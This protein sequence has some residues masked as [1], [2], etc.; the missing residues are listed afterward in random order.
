[1][2]GPCYVVQNFVSFLVAGEERVD[3]LTFIVF[4]EL[5]VAVIILSL[6]RGA[7]F[8]VCIV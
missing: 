5:Y 3:C 1:M 8:L 4:Q 7:V 6:P 2:F